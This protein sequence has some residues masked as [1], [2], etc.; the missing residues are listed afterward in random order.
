MCLFVSDFMALEIMEFVLTFH[1]DNF[2]KLQVLR[3][4]AGDAC[5][6][7]SRRRFETDRGKKS[8]NCLGN[9][10]ALS[11][12]QRGEYIT[13]T[14]VGVDTKKLYFNSLFDQSYKQ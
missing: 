14:T 10:Y 8:R 4:C 7:K 5:A 3:A 9:K 6:L 2:C 12:K 13:I 1:E 11:E